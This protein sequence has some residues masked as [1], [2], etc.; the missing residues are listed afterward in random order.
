MTV[1]DTTVTIP[2]DQEKIVSTYTREEIEKRVIENY[3]E[4]K[5]LIQADKRQ[6]VKN[7][8]RAKRRRLV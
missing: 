3:S 6:E 8:S 5:E 4:L 7:W 1:F 2:K